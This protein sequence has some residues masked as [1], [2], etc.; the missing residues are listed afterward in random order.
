MI[1]C[2]LGLPFNLISDTCRDMLSNY[3]CQ[4][5]DSSNQCLDA[6]FSLFIFLRRNVILPK[7]HP[8]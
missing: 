8:H 2:R 7:F 3:I 1:G 6:E 4:V 5:S